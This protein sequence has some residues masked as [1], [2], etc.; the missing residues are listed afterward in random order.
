MVSSAQIITFQAA[1][2]AGQIFG[3][4]EVPDAAMLYTFPAEAFDRHFTF[5][6]LASS[7]GNTGAVE[8]AVFVKEGLD[9][10][11]PDAPVEEPYGRR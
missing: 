9:G 4:F 2:P 10:A 6:V 3:P 11:G 8:V 5:E 1:T 7:G